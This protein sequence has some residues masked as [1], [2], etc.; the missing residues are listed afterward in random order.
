MA[1]YNEYPWPNLR[2]GEGS[3][4]LHG[5][6]ELTEMRAVA[7]GERK[8]PPVKPH[9]PEDLARRIAR[10]QLREDRRIAGS[11]RKGHQVPKMNLTR[12]K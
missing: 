10:E 9:S 1:G 12:S 11:R 5:Y 3:G 4:T 2:R 8:A 7:R 6:E